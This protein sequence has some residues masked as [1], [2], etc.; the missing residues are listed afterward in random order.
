M[1]SS[2]ELKDEMNRLE[3]DPSHLPFGVNPN[4]ISA[5]RIG[6]TPLVD[7]A[8][9]WVIRR[10]FPG[11]VLRKLTARVQCRSGAAS[12]R[13][14]SAAIDV[15]TGQPVHHPCMYLR[16]CPSTALRRGPWSLGPSPWSFGPGTKGTKGSGQGS[17]HR[18]ACGYCAY[19]V[20]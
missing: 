7:R 15:W 2:P 3:T 8:N 16:V 17:G 6:Q 11:L 1:A 18:P 19:I 14:W 10:A 20:S 9:D 12:N 4:C 5:R 13:G